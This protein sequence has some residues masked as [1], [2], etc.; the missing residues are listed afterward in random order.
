M[1]Q[2]YGHDTAI[3]TIQRALAE[4]RV[5][6][7]WLIAGPPRVGKTTLALDLARA[8]NCV[9]SGDDIPPC[10]A[11]GQC[12]RIASGIHPD[13]RVVG[14]ETARSGRLRTLISI[15]QVRDVQRELTLLPY[16]GASRVVIFE[17]AELFSE[18]AA[19]SLLKTLEEPP[20][21]VLILLLASDSASVLPTI[22]SR[23]RQLR[24]RPVPASIIARFLTERK[25]VLPDDAREIAGLAAGR[26]GWAVNAAEDP[27]LLEHVAETLD[28][29]ETVIAGA[30][31]D[32]FDYA[33][34]LARPLLR[35]PRL[36]VRRARPVAILVA[37]RAARRTEQEGTGGKRRATRIRLRRSRSAARRI[38][39]GGHQS[40]PARGVPASTQRNPTPC[41]R[42]HGAG[43][44][45]PRLTH[46]IPSPL[47]G[48]G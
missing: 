29:I 31:A 46:D 34:R 9:P 42:E 44:A 4:G 37:R 22:L 43:A 19:N 14:L 10:G 5:A 13:I 24:L 16:E 41:H 3:Q 38:R 17:S 11:C 26:I 33:E 39:S 30:L 32:R 48:E 2:T 18:E 28:G 47:M 25:A 23:C 20:D 8:V 15:E 21:R 40:R 27:S 36:R 35:G 12:R 45:D 6:H 7:S 1:W